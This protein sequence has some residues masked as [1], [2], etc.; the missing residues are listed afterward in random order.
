MAVLLK[1]MQLD[2]AEP[3]RKRQIEILQKQVGLCRESLRGLVSASDPQQ[4]I[5]HTTLRLFLDQ[6]LDHWQLLKPEV[7][8]HVERS[9]AESSVL[10]ESYDGLQQALINLLNNAAEAGGGQLTINSDVSEGN[11]V[12][13][14]TDKGPGITDELKSRLGLDVVSTK[15]SG[16]GVGFMLSHATLER[17]GGSVRLENAVAGGTLTR[18]RLPVRSLS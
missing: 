3:Q 4:N 9:E 10:L 18:I 2:E 16:L 12:F 13:E 1:D 11:W 15:Q 7:S 14:I 8:V 5:L 6:T 17:L